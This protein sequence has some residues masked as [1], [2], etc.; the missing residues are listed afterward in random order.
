MRQLPVHAEAVDAGVFGVAPIA[1]HPELHQLVRAHS[2]T[3]GERWKEKLEPLRALEGSETPGAPFSSWGRVLRGQSTY[4]QIKRLD[5][6]A[7]MVVGELPKEKALLL[8]LLLQ[9]LQR[10]R[11]AERENRGRSERETR[12]DERT[13]GGRGRRRRKRAWPLLLLFQA[14]TDKWGQGPVGRDG[15]KTKS[16]TY[17]IPSFSVSP[18]PLPEA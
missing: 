17:S 11:E 16:Y 18:K 2:I 8:S 14:K 4:L 3:L 12:S 5:R 13:R 9:A 7:V 10:G 15:G 1:Q 6:V